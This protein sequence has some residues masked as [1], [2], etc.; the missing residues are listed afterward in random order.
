MRPGMINFN[1]TRLVFDATS[2]ESVTEAE[3]RAREDVFRLFEVYKKHIGAFGNAYILD[4]GPYLGTRES[5]RIIGEYVLTLDDIVE[6]R[7]FDDAIA[8]G[9]G[10]VDFHHLDKQG[11]SALQFVKPNDI[12]YRTL[13]PQNVDNLLVAGR[14][15]SVTQMGA[16]VTRMGVTAM[17]MGEAAGRAAVLALNGRCAPRD[18]DVEQLRTLLLENGAVLNDRSNA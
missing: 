7:R 8:L 1:N 6:G 13:L 10:I 4:S 12:P 16:A 11:H 15:H 2:A 3:I 18:V 17:L 9:G 14:C 5:R